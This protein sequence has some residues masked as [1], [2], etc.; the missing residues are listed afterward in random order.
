MVAKEPARGDSSLCGGGQGF[1][2]DAEW[3]LVLIIV[4]EHF[5]AIGGAMR[6]LQGRALLV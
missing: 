5:K 6:A 1:A 4:H 2:D 3:W